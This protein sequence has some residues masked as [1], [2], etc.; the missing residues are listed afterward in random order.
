MYA[1]RRRGRSVLRADPHHRLR[2]YEQVSWEMMTDEVDE[3]NEG[4][5]RMGGGSLEMPTMEHVEC[6]EYGKRVWLVLQSYPFRLLTGMK[7]HGD[8]S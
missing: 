4:N 1:A 3:G 7:N 8:A 6:M 2:T 5:E